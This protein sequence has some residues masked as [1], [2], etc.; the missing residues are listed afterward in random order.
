MMNIISDMSVVHARSKVFVQL[1]RPV[2]TGH[3]MR[4]EL[5]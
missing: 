5:D 2:H 1:L 3:P 4:I